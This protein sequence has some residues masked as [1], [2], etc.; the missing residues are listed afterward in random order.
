MQTRIWHQT[1]VGSAVLVTMI[2]GGTVWAAST[3]TPASTRIIP[4]SLIAQTRL[5]RLSNV[6]FSDQ[7]NGDFR[8]SNYLDN[9]ASPST[10]TT[11]DA[12][13]TPNLDSKNPS[14]TASGINT[15]QD[16][17]ANTSSSTT[18]PVDNDNVS[19]TSSSAASTSTSAVQYISSAAT[20]SFDFTAAP[21]ASQVSSNAVDISGLTTTKGKHHDKGDRLSSV[22]V[23]PTSS[24]SKRVQKNGHHLPATGNQ[25]APWLIIPGLLSLVGA[26]LLLNNRWHS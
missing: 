9:A 17:E 23:T 22:K 4:T 3:S 20:P 12:T 6:P 21:S 8:L 15:K 1:L 7:F 24:S 10:P 5:E 25:I 26:G 11:L 2:G 18:V 14:T 13:T 19:T 16:T